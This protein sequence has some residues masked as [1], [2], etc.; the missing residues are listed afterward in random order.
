GTGKAGADH[1]G[2]EIDVRQFADRQLEEAENAEDHDRRHEQRRHDGLQD[3]LT[4]DIHGAFGA[5]AFAMET[6]LP[7]TTRSCPS[8]ITRSPLLT[9]PDM[10]IVAPPSNRTVTGRSCALSSLSTI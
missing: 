5:A 3:E 9:L 2:R 1:D 6:G 8:V 10:A 4:R 7:G